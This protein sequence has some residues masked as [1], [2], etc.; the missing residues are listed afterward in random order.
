KRKSRRSVRFGGMPALASRRTDAVVAAVLAIA[1]VVQVLAMPIAPHAVGVLIALSATI[2]VAFRRTHPVAALIAG[3]A[4]WAYP[5]DGYLVIG[6]VAAFLLLYSFSVA[7]DDIRIV[8]AAPV[9]LLGLSVSALL[10]NDEPTG[11]WLG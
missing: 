6:Y 4:W 2:P 11:E 9:I 5:T 10:R 8:V 1:S 3:T 7:V